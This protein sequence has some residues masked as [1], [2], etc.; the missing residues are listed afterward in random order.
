MYKNTV[1]IFENET[2]ICEFDLAS[3]IVIDKNVGV[4]FEQAN[5][6]VQT[7]R[8]K[9]KP[10]ID[11]AMIDYEQANENLFFVWGYFTDDSEES[12]VDIAKIENNK[13][14]F[15]HD[16]FGASPMVRETINKILT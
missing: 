15:S 2:Y 16:F 8:E 5:L 3:N 11:F 14:T 13:V 9:N 12:P 10:Y 1:K 7:Y 4:T 6:A